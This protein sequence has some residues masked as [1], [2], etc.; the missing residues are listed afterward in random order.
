VAGPS[1]AVGDADLGDKCNSECNLDHWLEVYCLAE[2]EYLFAK[3][4]DFEDTIEGAVL[5]GS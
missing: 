3:Q 1:L 2:E 5:A 4:A